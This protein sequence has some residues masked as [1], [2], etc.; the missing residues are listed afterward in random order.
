MSKAIIYCGVLCSLAFLLFLGSTGLVDETEPLFAEAGKGMFLTGDWITPYYNG[1]TRF[2]KPP[3]I[4]WGMAIAFHL[5][6]VNTWG[7]RLP[8]ALGAIVLTFVSFYTV[9][10]FHKSSNSAWL[11]PAILSF[12]FYSLAW[13]RTGVSDMLLSAGMG[14]GL[15]CFFTGY[16]EASQR[17]TTLSLWQFPSLWYSLSA[18]SLALAVLAK[19]PVG[20]VLPGLIIL[21]FLLYVGKCKTV[22]GEMGIIWLTVIFS[23]IAVPWFVLISQRHSDYIETFFGYHNVQRF[24]EVVSNH[25][26]PWYY[27]FIVLLILFIP[28]SLY[29]PG[30]IANTEFWRRRFWSQQS[31]PEQ[32]PLFAVIWVIAIFVF[33]SIASTKLPSY[34]LPL[35]PAASILISLYWGEA[36]YSTSMLISIIINLIFVFVLA[37]AFWLSPRFI[38]VD[39]AVADLPQILA[40]SGIPVLAGLIWFV[41]GLSL[42]FLLIRKQWRWIIWSNII[43]FIFFFL[44]VL[45]PTTFLMDTVRQY[46]LRNLANS[47]VEFKQPAEEILMLGFRKPSL[48]FYSGNNLK[49]FRTSNSFTDYWETLQQDSV[50]S[51]LIV[52]YIDRLENFYLNQKNYEIL[53]QQA[54]YL[55]LRV[56]VD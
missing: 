9:L 54:I 41:C 32:L 45:I 52:T 37:I 20:V 24:T 25:P 11:V 31:P 3:L 55:L 14:C 29:L 2:D 7:V 49:F 15:L 1:E 21:A 19:G 46:P 35:I 27:Y 26:G 48:V 13:G 38:D 23:V 30:A 12:N 4:Y 50:D 6:G 47:I 34:I 39:V 16:A 43:T 28:W 53:D 17:K 42:I 36:K 5:F 8:S 22:V 18:V 51:V 33:F 40:T 56:D 10:R 44:F